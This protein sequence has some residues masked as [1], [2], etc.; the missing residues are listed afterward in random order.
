[1]LPLLGLGLELGLGLGL[2]QRGP[3]GR[4][5]AK[6]RWPIV[7][8]VEAHVVVVLPVESEV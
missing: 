6:E 8:L 2:A 7:E 1:M 5:D 4:V 3:T